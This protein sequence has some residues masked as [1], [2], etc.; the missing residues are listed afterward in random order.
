MLQVIEDFLWSFR[1]RKPGDYFKADYLQKLARM[2]KRWSPIYRFQLSIH[3]AFINYSPTSEVWRCYIAVLIW[4]V[5]WLIGWLVHMMG[6][7]CIAKCLWCK[8][9]LHFETDWNK[10]WY[11]CY[12]KYM[13]M[14]RCVG[15]IFVGGEDNKGLYAFEHVKLLLVYL[16]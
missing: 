10:A 5:G 13:M 14:C 9:L 6:V 15:Q 12:D 8:L 16:I 2:F 4:M 11:I 1:L 3:R 7:S